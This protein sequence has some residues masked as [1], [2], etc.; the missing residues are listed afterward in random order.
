MP[1]LTYDRTKPINDLHKRQVVFCRQKKDLIKRSMELSQ[2][3][4]CKVLLVVFDPE[5]TQMSYFSSQKD[6][7]L[8]A[9]H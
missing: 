7:T 9:A 5:K 4:E 2:M 8:M 3:C 1:K 6:F